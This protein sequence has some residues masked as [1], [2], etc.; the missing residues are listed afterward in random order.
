MSSLLYLAFFISFVLIFFNIKIPLIVIG[1]IVLLKLSFIYMKL[2]YKGLGLPLFV[3]WVGGLV[4][5]LVQKIEIET[6]VINTLNF[7]ING[8]P[9]TIS[10]FYIYNFI[11]HLSLWILLMMCLDLM[12]AFKIVRNE[13]P[14]SKESSLFLIKTIGFMLVPLCLIAVSKG[15][16]IGLQI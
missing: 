5:L 1:I 6:N 7:E 9:L 11:F 10:I 3:F 8:F 16:L 14:K 15:E 13:E 4:F 2:M 12:K